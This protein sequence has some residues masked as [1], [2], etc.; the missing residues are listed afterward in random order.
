MKHPFSKAFSLS[1]LALLASA[2]HAEPREVG[3]SSDFVLYCID[4][5]YTHV[6]EIVLTGD[7]L[8]GDSVNLRKDMVVHSAPGQ[9][10]TLKMSGANVPRFTVNAG[11][12]LSFRDVVIDGG[13]NQNR[14][15]AVFYLS[16][17]SDTNNIARLTFDNGVTMKDVYMKAV[18][19]TGVEH[20]APIT[21]SANGRFIF[22]RGACIQDCTNNRGDGGAIYCDSGAIVLGGGRITGCRAKGS[23]GAIC[24]VG[25]R[26]T[27]PELGETDESVAS[28]ARGDIFFY[29]GEITGNQC[30]VGSTDSE[31]K[32]HY[33]GGIYL[34]DTGPMLFV[35]GPAVVSNNVCAAN[36]RPVADD[37]ST[38]NL[39]STY[40]NRL[41]L[42]GDDTGSG[43]TFNGG[44]IGVRFPDVRA[45][46]DS[47]IESLVQSQRFG[48]IWWEY[49]S[50]REEAY[51]FFWNG[52]NRYRGWI[53]GNAEGNPLMWSRFDIYTLPR[54]RDRVLEK[55]KEHNPEHPLYVELNDDFTADQE[56][57]GDHY[58]RIPAGFSVTVD[59][60]GFAFTGCVQVA[61]G[62]HV[63]IRDR[64]FG[65]TGTFY[66]HRDVTDDLE[67]DKASEDYKNAYSIEAGTFISEI[68]DV[69]IAEGSE[70]LNNYDESDKYTVAARA[71]RTEGDARIADATQCLL[72][73]VDWEIRDVAFL[74]NGEPDIDEITYSTGDW[75]HREYTNS[76]YHVQVY[77][78]PAI[79]IKNPDGSVTL[80]EV[81]RFGVKMDVGE[82]LLLYSSQRER[83]EATSDKDALLPL[84]RED[85]FVWREH[86]YDLIK[87][88]HITTTQVGETISTNHV[89]VAYFRFPPPA[90][91]ATQRKSGVGQLPI[92][93]VAHLLGSLGYSRVEGFAQSSVDADLDERHPNGLRM[94]ENLVTGT[95]TNHL[96][97]GAVKEAE[98]GT[99]L[100][101]TMTEPDKVHRVDTDYSVHYDLRKALPGGE[102]TRVGDVK[103]RPVFEV[104]LLDAEGKSKNATGYYRVTTLIVPAAKHQPDG[105]TLSVTNEIPCTNIVGVLEVDSTFTNTLAA[106]PWRELSVDPFELKD[107]AMSISNY[108]CIGQ[109]TGDDVVQVADQG[110]VYHQWTW[111]PS[112][113]DPARKTWEGVLTVTKDG[114][115]EAIPSDQFRTARN[116]AAWMTR[117]VPDAK[118]FFLV[119]QYSPAPITLTIAAGAPEKDKN[120]CTLVTNPNLA[121]V[122][123]NDYAW[124]ANPLPTDLISL[125]NGN[126]GRMLLRWRTTTTDGVTTGTWGQWV[127]NPAEFK[128]TWRDDYTVKAGTGFW[129]HRTGE[130]FTIPLPQDGP[131][132]GKE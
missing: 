89:D 122:R 42:S 91:K 48:S 55:L 56:V 16:S 80:S 34:G 40:A 24:T 39:D 81:D 37:V 68:P 44:W 46:D 103:E 127:F 132:K 131:G 27:D 9:R 53:G 43:L 124:G 19:G 118:P 72:E 94:W 4:N 119:G 130:A 3:S 45:T 52:D 33:G 90:F 21:V 20:R 12:H 7:I 95:E 79:E 59:L 88:I 69:W 17:S 87:L 96:L 74:E 128:S 123:L 107:D 97:V 129:Y 38:Y 54:D 70:L 108:V 66:G 116:T 64:S 101:L 65:R 28:L 23:G 30:G 5:R 115:T 126:N 41:K 26:L 117:G 31:T 99:K 62:G 57:L 67:N 104:D 22:K 125:P 58:M 76:H 15:D 78:A 10:Y 93:V 32:R 61:R 50:T 63:T 106:V 29:E 36:G 35:I 100:T 112:D 25:K 83:D 114:V 113:D 13:N 86:C 6:D 102:W 92:T 121:D 47:E 77:A 109:L 111:K 75:V 98:G 110:H 2:A 82:R 60:N 8:L 11:V 51:Q 18:T 85:A 1:V 84:N 120:V 71:W 49:K 73:N 105:Q 14:T